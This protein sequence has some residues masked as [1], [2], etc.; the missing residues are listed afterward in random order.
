MQAEATA[1]AIKAVAAAIRSD[2]GH[3]ASSYRVAEQYIA[4]FGR[5]AQGSNT[6]VVPANSS[7]VGAMVAQVTEASNHPPARMAHYQLTV[8]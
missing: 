5:L 7:D 2:G 4:A 3:E 1:A 8:S 6:L